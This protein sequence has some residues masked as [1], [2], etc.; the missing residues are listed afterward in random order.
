MPRRGPGSVTH[1]ALL[2]SV[3]ILLGYGAGILTGWLYGLVIGW[4]AVCI[5]YLVNVWRVIWP[6]D[7]QATRDHANVED[8]ARPITELLILSASAASLIAVG[9]L[10][11]NQRLPGHSTILTAVL[12]I[13]S[14]LLSWALIHTVYTLRYA[15]EYYRDSPRGTG[16]DFNTD[17]LAQYTDFAYFAFDLGMT[18]Q[19]ADTDVSTS[20][21]RKIIFIHTLLAY[22]FNTVILASV[23]N[24]AISMT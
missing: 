19:V 23:V 6:M 18:F 17:D 5:L 20:R 15:R 8:P 21:L 14:V 9:T 4:G 2:V 3:G 22:A 1:I 16:I 24:L 12:P 7:G 11:L 13:L 10:I